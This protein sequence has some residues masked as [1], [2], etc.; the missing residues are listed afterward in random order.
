VL[1]AAVEDLGEALFGGRET[2]DDDLLAEL[3][4]WT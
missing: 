1:L 3:G 4:I 2:I